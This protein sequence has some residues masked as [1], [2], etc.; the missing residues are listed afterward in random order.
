[1]QFFPIFLKYDVIVTHYFMTEKWFS[2]CTQQK[3][4]S[5]SDSICR[6][7]GS[8]VEESKAVFIKNGNGTQD[9]RA[10]AENFDDEK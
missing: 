5:Y 3:L 1:M 7:C 10:I 2:F 4:S 8:A 9:A 6:C